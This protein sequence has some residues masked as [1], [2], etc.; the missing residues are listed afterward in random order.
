MIE[1]KAAI[2]FE[3]KAPLQIEQI[4]VEEP[5]EGE[6]LV[7]MAA[8]SI[9]HLDYMALEGAFRYMR[10]PCVM[11]HEG[12][13]TVVQTGANVRSLQVGD[14]VVPL[15]LPECGQCRACISQVSNSCEAHSDTRHLGLMP[16]GTSRYRL[17]GEPLYHFLG[18]STLS[19]YIV[20]PEVAL[21]RINANISFEASCLLG[22]T[23]TSGIG[24]VLNT[25]RIQPGSTV[26]VF[27]LGGFGLSVIQGAVMGQAGRIIGIDDNIDKFALATEFGA[28]ECLNPRDYADPIEQVI[29]ELTKG[30]VDVSFDCI[31]TETMIQAAIA[32][33]HPGWGKTVM[34]SH[35]PSTSSVLLSP[36]AMAYG[37]Q[38]QGVQFGG[39]KGRSQLP[40]FAEQ[41][42]H[43]EIKVEPLITHRLNLSDVNLSFDLLQSGQSIRSIIYFP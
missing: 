7:K 37:R 13:G 31:S 42:Q 39:V 9:C 1:S 38:W 32:S 35:S 25:A 3:P 24:A 22:C 14:H 20:V 18:T 36:D 16:N 28:T 15:Y 33:T 21:A 34:V 23:L 12:S 19:E 40:G 8:A 2:A 4:Q 10:F 43:E 17:N 5:G 6:V 26:A 29:F 11:G 27:G 30:G 41:I